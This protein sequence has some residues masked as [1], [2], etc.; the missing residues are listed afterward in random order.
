MPKV[1]FYLL[2][3]P[4][5]TAVLLTVCRLCEK[6]YDQQK[7]VYIQ[8]TSKHDAELLDKLLWTY[9]DISFLPHGLS[10]AKMPIIIAYSDSSPSEKYDIL[11]NLTQNTPTFFNQFQRVIEVVSGEETQ[12]QAARLRYRFY[13]DNQCELHSHQL[14]K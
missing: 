7:T 8:T 14:Q 2:E 6:A 3:N 9:N 11:V 12:R 4:E 5:N 13:R 1:D 10:P